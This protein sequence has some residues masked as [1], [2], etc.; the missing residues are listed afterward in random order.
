MKYTPLILLFFTSCVS[1][2]TVNFTNLNYQVLQNIE[3]VKF[4]KTNVKG[5]LVSTNQIELTLFK[6]GVNQTIL[7]KEIKEIRVKNYSPGKTAILG[8]SLL[9]GII[10]ILPPFPAL[11]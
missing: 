1:Y 3:V 9:T 4:E 2:N 8:L 10:V 5:Q 11:L 6:N 7:K